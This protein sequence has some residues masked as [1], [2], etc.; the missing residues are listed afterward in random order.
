M[1]RNEA[2][3]LIERQAREGRRRVVPS[4]EMLFHETAGD[5]LEAIETAEW[6]AAS[7][8][9]LSPEQREVVELKIY[10]DLTFREISEVTGIPQGTVATRYRSALEKLRGQMAEERE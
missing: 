2:I 10:A 9:R 5:A 4:A 3:R 1:A 7:L 6:V 8:A